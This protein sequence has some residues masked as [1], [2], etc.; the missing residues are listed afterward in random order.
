MIYFDI[1]TLFPKVFEEYFN[2]SILKRA[3]EKKLIKIKLHDL[4]NWTKDKR[5]TVDDKPYGGG[6]GMILKVEPLYL[7]IQDLT[8]KIKNKPKNKDKNNK[9]DRNDFKVI[10]L[11]PQGKLFNQKKALRYSRLKRIILICGHYEGFDSRIEK[12]IDEKLSIGEYVL[13][14]GE[15]PA[16][17]VVD[18]VSRLIPKVIK[19]ESLKE[20]SFNLSS[21][22]EY[23]QYTRPSV[24][25]YSVDNKK[26][27][28]KQNK[29]N[30]K[31]QIKKLKVPK[32]LLS[33]NH[34]KIK[35]WKIKKMK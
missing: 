10:L 6:P 34:Q 33:G 28:N 31:K 13:T 35:E 11:S 20:E 18:A 7:A 4:R 2:Q 19:Q 32:V 8:K 14:G 26:T 23:P 12:F 27:N 3:Q 25:E 5:K 16:M 29:K 30:K 1:I 9:K 24:F 15:I 21:Q 22:K 17:V